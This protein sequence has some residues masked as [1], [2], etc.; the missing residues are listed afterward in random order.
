MAVVS[1]GTT[2]PSSGLWGER[3]AGLVADLKT[4]FL[5]QVKKKKKLLNGKT[6]LYPS[7]HLRSPEPVDALLV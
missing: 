3:Q 7:P 5:F 6:K 2:L 4:P 1:A